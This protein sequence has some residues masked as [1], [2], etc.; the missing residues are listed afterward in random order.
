MTA[1]VPVSHRMLPG[2]HERAGGPECRCGA[3]WDRVND[4]CAAPAQTPAGDEE[5]TEHFMQALDEAEGQE[6]EFEGGP[7]IPDKA[8]GAAVLHWCATAGGDPW[9]KA[10][11][12]LAAAAPFTVAANQPDA[13]EVE[14]LRAQRD[15]ALAVRPAKMQGVDH[16]A[17][18]YNAARDEF[19]RVL[20]VEATQ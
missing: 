20:G 6:P 3:P 15:A 14:R 12:A 10:R 1:P 16:Y 13:A 9:P 2:S 5:M 7:I 11:A 8:A 19:R 4:R 18:G 17:M